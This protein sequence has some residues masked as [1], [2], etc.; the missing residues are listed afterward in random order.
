ME[1]NNSLNQDIMIDLETASLKELEAESV[2]LHNAADYYDSLQL[3]T[4]EFLNIVY[5]G[6][7][8]VYFQCFNLNVAES[9]T[10]QSQQM[11]RVASTFI[12]NYF[13]MVFPKDVALHKELGI[14]S[15][16]ASK[17]SIDFKNNRKD[18]LGVI[19]LERYSDTDSVYVT[20]ETLIEYFSIPD[21]KAVEWILKLNR[22]G[23]EP[24]IGQCFE[25]YSKHFNCLSNTQ[26]LELEKISFALQM[27]AKKRYIMDNAWE[28]PHIFHKPL[29]KLMYTGIEVNQS[30]TSS[31]ARE[32]I[33]DFIHY[34]F[35]KFYKRDVNLSDFI[36]RIKEYRRKFMME[37][38]E[39]I[40]QSYKVNNYDK[41][42]LNDKTEYLFKKGTP[43]HCKG[44]AFH[45]YLLNNNNGFANKFELI[46]S[47]DKVKCY[48]CKP[49]DVNDI[50]AKQSGYFS[51]HTGSYPYEYA[52]PID[53]DVEFEKQILKPINRIVSN[54]RQT[55][56]MTP[57]EEQRS[58]MEIVP[59]MLKLKA[60]F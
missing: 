43:F 28:E 34:S 9:I 14:D 45:N 4:K 20:F 8:S 60:L 56:N 22:K 32:C 10:L 2:R 30:S 31:F 58:K 40:T 47:G 27:H 35:D 18:D 12:N 13:N 29:D 6:T 16:L 57:E 51:F 37:N 19:T 39:R 42:I 50:I 11:T 54:L 48:E 25:A 36:E 17:Y 46:N 44:A 38:P 21:D 53:Y 24:F 1:V 3:G 26:S 59:N 33:I 55:F 23:L 52:P 5:G 49:R 15:E 7:A 41:Y